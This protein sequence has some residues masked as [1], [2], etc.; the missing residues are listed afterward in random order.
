MEIVFATSNSHKI[1]EAKG[2]LGESWEIVTPLDLGITDEIPED[3]PTL[4]ENALFKATYIFEKCGKICFADDTGLEVDW[5]KGAPGVRS[6]RYASEKSDALLNM[7]K[8][9]KELN[10]VENRKARFRTVIALKGCGECHLFE[11]VLNGTISTDPSGSAG[12]GYDP[13]FIP[14]GYTKSLAELTFFEKNIISHR[15]KAI[16]KLSEF[17]SYYTE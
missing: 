2:I 16:R 14:D 6:A 17:L 10:G 1:N 4:Q 5:L 11:G 15:G 9:L 12:F 13:I 3:A 7:Q 8:L